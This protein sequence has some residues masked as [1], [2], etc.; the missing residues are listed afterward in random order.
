MNESSVYLKD[1]KEY[2]FSIP[3]IS[4]TFDL[5][6]EF[7]LITSVMQIERQSEG[8]LVLKGEELELVS[9]FLNDQNVETTE[10]IL[11]DKEL[12]IKNCPDTFKLSIVTRIKPQ[13]N[14]A[15]LGLYQ[16]GDVLCTMCEAEGFR[17]IT[18][19]PDRPDVLSKFETTIIANNNYPVLLSNGNFVDKGT[20]QDDR[21]W[22]K[23][24]DPFKKPTY[25]FGLVA[26]D[27]SS[28][29]SQYET[30]SKRKINLSMYVEKGHEDK[31][32]LA[33]ETLA[34]AMRFDE[35]K[36]NLEC[37]LDEYNLVA[38]EKFNF[39]AQE[40]KGLNL[41]NAKYVE[42]SFLTPD[43]DFPW[44]Q[45]TIAHEYFHNWTG[46]RV[47]IR[48]WFQLT[49]KEGLTSFRDQK[50]IESASGSMVNR[51]R[52]IKLIREKQFSEDS[53]AMA[54]PPRPQ[55]YQNID[56]CYTHTIYYKGAEIFRM[57][58]TIFGEEGFRAGL[59]LFFARYDGQAA[60]LENFISA[61]EHI[62]NC[63][64][65]QFMQWF[66]VAGT[67][68]VDV[69]S[70]FDNSM[71]NLTFTQSCKNT[72]VLFHIPLKVAFFNAQGEMIGEHLIE[73][74]DK[75]TS[76]QFYF[77]GL[78][79]KPAISL[80][81]NFSAPIILQTDFKEQDYFKL[82][83]FET[84]FFQKFEMLH[85]LSLLEIVKLYAQK[86]R[87]ITQDIRISEDLIYAYRKVLL[88]ESL[89]GQIR[90]EI[91]TIPSCED[92]IRELQSKNH[93]IDIIEIE[94]VRRYFQEELGFG[95][96]N[97]LK[98]TYDRLSAAEDNSYNGQA[99]NRRALKNRVLA[100]LMASN[101]DDRTLSSCYA[102]YGQSETITDQL[103]SLALTNLYAQEDIRNGVL[104]D[105][106]SRYQAESHLIDEWFA[107]QAM[108]EDK[109][110]LNRIKALTKHSHFDLQ[111]PNRV[112]SLISTFASHNYLIFHSKDGSG[113]EFLADMLLKIDALNPTS[114][115]QI[116]K[117]FTRTDFFNDER[118]ELVLNVIN[119]LMTNEISDNLKELLTTTIN[120]LTV[121]KGATLKENAVK[122][123]VSIAQ[124]SFGLIKPPS[125][126]PVD[127]GEP[128]EEL[129]SPEPIE[130]NAREEQQFVRNTT[131]CNIS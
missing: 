54:H 121:N 94:N 66:D 71:V 3:N 91:L 112:R 70:S 72:D 46:N 106:F 62:N 59:E 111:N 4:L 129:E 77:P 124:S 82:A 130:G 7:A 51:L 114:A 92:V 35:D 61:F 109:D 53:G 19:H 93:D 110:A 28:V 100:L 107:V 31:C 101:P 63:D 64:L 128:S 126:N 127:L 67:P 49:L 10:L 32:G 56:N 22:V 37:D 55:S 76:V 69:K 36:Y 105:F 123:R 119:S 104:E 131:C 57:L 2:P 113:Y 125:P 87:I 97:E 90:A 16:S 117:V 60:T 122:P 38:I 44:I 75:N 23:Y 39:G 42:A 99:F 12:V 27:L 26:G 115:A 98:N 95:L 118:K 86:H 33:L 20:L 50:Y 89:D 41:F 78:E 25:L 21:H 88:D 85:K 96:C 30:K 74:K 81:R 14:T 6:D 79:Q 80:L 73:L 11:N 68:V 43:S 48:D 45:G 65:T 18:Y 40:S 15:L 102:Q 9:I 84:D 17:R 24:H 8:D 83:E 1:Y 29:K 103:Q 13:E 52:D 5:H 47:T 58:E 116:A 34:D 108:S 120:A